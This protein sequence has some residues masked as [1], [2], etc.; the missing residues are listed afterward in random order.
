VLPGGPKKPRK[1]VTPDARTA[2]GKTV[3]QHKQDALKKG[4]KPDAAE[5]QDKGPAA[6]DKQLQQGLA[7]LDA[8]TA[9]YAGDG[10]TKE[11]VETGVKSVRRKFKVFKSITVVDGGDTWDYEYVASPATR[12]KGAK[13]NTKKSLLKVQDLLGVQVVQRTGKGADKEL[14]GP[15]DGYTYATRDN[16]VYIRHLPDKAG[17]KGYPDVHIDDAGKLQRG[18]A[19]DA[20]DPEQVVADYQKIIAGLKLTVPEPSWSTPKKQTEVDQYRRALRKA[21]IETYGGSLKILDEKV[22]SSGVIPAAYNKIR[23]E[24]FEE[25]VQENSKEVKRE[26]KPWFVATRK[27]MLQKDRSADGRI[28]GSKILAEIK[29]LEE[30]RLPSSEEKSQMDDYNT[31]ITDKIPWIAKD[32]KTKL[33]FS[34]VRYYFNNA[35]VAQMWKKDLTFILGSK[36]EVVVPEV[37]TAPAASAQKPK[38]P[39]GGG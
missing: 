24:I 31:I 22:L 25:W 34:K 7:A 38:K 23:G 14:K 3:A 29:S 4:Q 10:A 18:P 19:R 1:G 11:E 36:H 21:A 28:E 8:V 27:N 20:P 5:K 9:R 17:K 39:T 15:P 37:P 12:K 6:D 2:D 35:N 30:P 16:R 13:Q 33:T 26:P 32:G